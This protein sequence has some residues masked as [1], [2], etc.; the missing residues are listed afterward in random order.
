MSAVADRLFYGFWTFPPLRFLYFNIAQS[1]AVFYGRND[2]HYYASQ[3]YPLLL[4][5]VLP[6]ALVGLY[7][8]LKNNTFTAA[9]QVQTAI[10]VQLATVCLVMPFV[11]S[12]ISHKE[13]RFIYPLLPALHI[14]AAPPL[15]QFF[16]PAIS[17]RSSHHTPR[18]LT[19]IFLILVNVVIAL[20]T[21]L[22]HASGILNVL[23][24]LRHQ[25]E[26]HSPDTKQPSL[27]PSIGT[28]EHGI[29]AGFLMP[30]HSTPW[31]S[32]LIYPTI[33]AWALSCEPPI[34]FTPDQKATYRDEADQFYDDPA[35]FLRTNM[36]G[37]LRH[38]P[39]RPTYASGPRSFTTRSSTSQTTYTHDWP[40]YLIFFAQLEQT[41]AP[42]LRGSSYGECWRTWNTAWHDDWRRTGDIVVWCLD[43]AEQDTWRA[44]KHRQIQEHRDRKFDSIVEAIKKEARE[45]QKRGWR[46]YLPT[47]SS[48]S[49]PW[50]PST[51]SLTW[52]RRSMMELSFPR[53][54]FSW[55]WG[56]RSRTHALWD[57][58]RRLFG[59]QS[60][61]ME[62]WIP[63]LPSWPDLPPWLGGKSK[64]KRVLDRDLWS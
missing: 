39:R 28:P 2:W 59:H 50:S 23:T 38:L 33:N 57:N 63:S 25:H 47:S 18:R 42:L 3:G 20:Y 46:D 10:R 51:S 52:W 16:Y 61:G 30:C 26:I 27:S 6:F 40:D 12:L 7:R 21:T 32:H 24:Y 22:Y 5:T 48:V 56:A 62:G 41:L 35:T 13:V 43:M 37:G 11:L 34:D 8:T 53:F 4:T 44:E 64:S 1:L 60:R 19:L 29:T 54:H 58:T 45:R 49:F 31:R 9:D 17:S 55:P 14:L 15:V 36:A